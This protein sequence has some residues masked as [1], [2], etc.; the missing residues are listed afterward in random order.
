MNEDKQAICNALLAALQ[1]TRGCIDLVE[2]KYEKI[3]PQDVDKGHPDL[4]TVYARFEN[5]AVKA[6]NVTWD[7]GMAMIRDIAGHID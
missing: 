1:L 5:G 3:A 6:I 7:S 4:E 2:L